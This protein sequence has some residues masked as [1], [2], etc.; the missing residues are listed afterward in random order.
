[1]K[2]SEYKKRKWHEKTVY[3]C[4]YCHFDTFEYA[5]LEKHIE[6][7]HRVKKPRKEMK[8]KIYDRFGN[9]IKEY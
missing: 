8:A 6:N 7:T 4:A 3:Q 2:K 5:E 9:E 1:M